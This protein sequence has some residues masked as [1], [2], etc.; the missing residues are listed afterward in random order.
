M[1]KLKKVGND[2][3]CS[4]QDNLKVVFFILQRPLF[5]YESFKNGGETY[6]GELVV[7]LMGVSFTCL[8]TMKEIG[9]F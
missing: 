7:L 8:Q 3:Y 4:N 9:V 5:L 2:V 1:D 6:N